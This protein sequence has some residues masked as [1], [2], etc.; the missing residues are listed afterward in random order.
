VAL[1]SRQL[2]RCGE[3]I[4]FFVA[5][6]LA[7]FAILDEP[8]LDGQSLGVFK[9]AL[10]DCRFYLEYGSGGSTILAARLQKRFISVDT[11]PYF[12]ESVR[13][14]IGELAPDQHLVHADV[15][16]TGPWGTPFWRRL[17]PHT[18]NKWTNSLE[19]PWRYMQSREGQDHPMLPDLI[20]IDGRFRV[21]ATLVCCA[22]LTASP[23]TRI[24]VDDYAE[25]PHYHVIEKYATLTATA[26]R[27]AIFQAAPLTSIE[28]LRT[29]I[30]E[31]S[32]D[33]R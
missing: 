9:S 14:K 18:L 5:Q 8:Y 16:L 15:G 24:F 10:E 17:T 22:H 1:I 25:S 19:A 20:L 27:I 32:A 21:A 30:A 3:L 2:A 29:A 28:D 13:K 12:L 33:W 26:G 31:Y 4:Q 7:G 23:G 6:R 11:D